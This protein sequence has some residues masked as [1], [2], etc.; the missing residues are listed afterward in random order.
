[1]RRSRSSIA[2]TREHR[3]PHAQ[4]GQTKVRIWGM[5]PDP[6]DKYLILVIKNYTLNEDHWEI[7]PPTLVQHDR[8]QEDCA[9]D[10]MA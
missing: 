8:H 9:H 5:Q 2:K 7:G 6:F 1:M 3:S 10:S 4:R